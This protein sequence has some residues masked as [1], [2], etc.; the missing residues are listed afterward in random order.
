VAV[1]ASLMGLFSWSHLWIYIVANLLGGA[2]AAG[3]FILT[4]PAERPSELRAAGAPARFGLSK[5]AA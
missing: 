1:G 4:E 2:A 3:A 5:D